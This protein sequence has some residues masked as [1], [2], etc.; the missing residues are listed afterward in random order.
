RF[1]SEHAVESCVVELLP[2]S[3][4]SVADCRE[5]QADGAL[6]H[7]ILAAEGLPEVS[8]EL[9][10]EGHFRKEQDPWRWRGLECLGGLLAA[11][12][13]LGRGLLLA[14]DARLLV[15]LAAPRLGKNAVLLDP[16]REALQR[17][18]E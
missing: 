11:L 4:L 1:A 16:L 6:P 13:P 5:N 2:G 7:L 12:A 10:F 3:D 15:V 14:P 17:R 18:F 9:F 8:V